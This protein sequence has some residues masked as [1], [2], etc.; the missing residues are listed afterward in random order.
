M[1]KYKFNSLMKFIFYSLQE[2]YTWE[3]YNSTTN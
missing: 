3:V 2:I 1:I